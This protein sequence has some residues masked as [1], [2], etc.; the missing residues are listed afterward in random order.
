MITTKKQTKMLLIEVSDHYCRR[1]FRSQTSDN[2]N[3]WKS[4]GGES[5]RREEKRREEKSRAE[6]SRAEKRR[7]EKRRRGK[8]SKKE[9]VG[10]QKGKEVAKHCFSHALKLRGSKSS[11]AKAGCG[12]MRP[13]E[14][15]SRRCGP[16]HIS[17]LS[18]RAL[19]GI[20]MSK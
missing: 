17:N 15:F 16:K 14:T 18:F 3:K 7:E 13:D 8:E 9:G 19:L 12:A 1:K 4:R 6:Q 11:L 2:M 10:A 5:Q 20:E